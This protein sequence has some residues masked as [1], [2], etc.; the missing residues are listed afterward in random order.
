MKAE[1]LTSMNPFPLYAFW[2]KTDVHTDVL[3]VV[4]SAVA[5]YTYVNVLYVH[6]I[7]KA[8]YITH[9]LIPNSIRYKSTRS[10]EKGVDT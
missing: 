7:C 10:G 3:V 6:V 4:F 8:G 5:A 1:M 9:K 2:T